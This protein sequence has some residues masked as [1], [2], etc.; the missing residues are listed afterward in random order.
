MKVTHGNAH[1]A[2]IEWSVHITYRKAVPQDTLDCIA[3]RGQTRENA[4]SVEE[5]EAV[6]VTAESWRAGIT[7]GALPGYV[8]TAEGRMV[9]YCFGDRDTG[10]VV[11]LALLPAYEGLGIGKALL[12]LVVGELRGLGFNRLFLGCSSDPTVRSHGFYRYLGWQPTGTVDDAGDEV[13]EY[14]FAGSE[15]PFSS[16]P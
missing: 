12:D 16:Q 1:S 14:V 6:G 7:S 15:T 11:V 13:L 2:F 9:G 5:L 10:E 3:L 8:G 4:F